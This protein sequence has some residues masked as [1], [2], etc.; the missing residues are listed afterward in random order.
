MHRRP[1]SHVAGLVLI[2]LVTAAGADDEID[3]TRRR[4]AG[5]PCALRSA[6]ARAVG[7]PRAGTTPPAPERMPASRPPGSR[8]DS[9]SRDAAGALAPEVVPSTPSAGPLL[10]PLGGPGATSR[11]VAPVQ[12]TA[13]TGPAPPAG[14]SLVPEVSKVEPGQVV[15]YWAS[16]EEAEAALPLIAVQAQVRPATRSELDRLGGVVVVFQLPNAA[17]AAQFRARIALAFPAAAVDFNTLYRPLQSQ[18]APRLYLPQKVDWPAQAPAQ[19][20]TALVRIGIVDGPIAPIAALGGVALSPR[21]FLAAGDVP[22]SAA[23][24][25]A[26]AALISGTDRASGFAGLAGPALLYSAEIMRSAG[27]EDSTSSATLVRA[28]DWLLGEGVQ[29]INLSLGGP[30]DAVTARAFAQLAKWPVVVVAAAGN[31]GPA[32]PPAFPAAYPG[33]IAVT[34]TDA[35]DRAYAWANRG[36]YIAMAAP[37]VDVWVPDGLSGHYVT[38]TSF[39]AAVATSA[40]A[41]LVRRFPGLDAIGARQRMCSTAKDLGVPG[42]DPVFGCGLLQVA[43]SL[44]DVRH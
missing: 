33:V 40:V 27:R 20:G 5:L 11:R 10:A 16:P 2:L 41:L 32:A 3:C 31:G 22:A 25:T 37:G 43:A 30:G 9:A 35:A 29:V 36:A 17:D 21:S 26:I 1:V 14:S 42:H 18:G 7:A 4:V 15:V 12:V 28:L 38:G 6:P 34:A 24:A 23:H 39:S 19:P 8:T 13:P 44:A